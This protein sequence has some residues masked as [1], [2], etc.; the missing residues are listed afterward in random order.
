MDSVIRERV[1]F[2]TDWPMFRYERALEEIGR[3]E[4]REESRQRFLH[5]NAKALLERIL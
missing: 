3:L 1:I 4:L 2:G 5:D